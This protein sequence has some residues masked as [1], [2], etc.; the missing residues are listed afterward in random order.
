MAGR[1]EGADGIDAASR[2][3]DADWGSVGRAKNA[4][5]AKDIAGVGSE[6]NPRKFLRAR[7]ASKTTGGYQSV[8]R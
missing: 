3:E 8:I 7:G 2:A 1:A 6:V 4:E 5:G